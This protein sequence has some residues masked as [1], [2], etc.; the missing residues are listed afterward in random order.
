LEARGNQQL[1]DVEKTHIG[2]EQVAQ[3]LHFGPNHKMN[4]WEKTHFESNS[5]QDRGFDLDFHLY[6]LEW[7]PGKH[8]RFCDFLCQCV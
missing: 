7:T 5:P 8:L 1:F 3:S 6:Q 4:A 2:V